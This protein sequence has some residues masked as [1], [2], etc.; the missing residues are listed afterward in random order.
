V[1]TA[2]EIKYL[3]E[4]YGWTV[5]PLTH[6][7][8]LRMTSDQCQFHEL[9]NKAEYERALNEPQEKAA[10]KK[11]AE[12]QDRVKAENQKISEL[13]AGKKFWTTQATPE[14]I[15]SAK[16]ALEACEKRYPQLVGSSVKSESIR[17]WLLTNNLPVTVAN[18]SRAFEALAREGRLVL[19]PAACGIIRIQMGDGQVL[20]IL[21][22]EL[23]AYQRKNPPTIE[24]RGVWRKTVQ[25]PIKILPA[26]ESVTGSELASHPLLKTL[27]QSFD[28]ADEAKRRQDAMSA[29]E[30]RNAH[31]EAWRDP[32]VYADAAK[33]IEQEINSFVSFHPEY[34]LTDENRKHMRAYLD[35][36]NLSYTL[37]NLETAYGE[38]VKEGYVQTNPEAVVS[39]GATKLVDLGAQ[40]PTPR[41]GYRPWDRMNSREFEAWVRIPANKQLVEDSYATA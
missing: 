11:A 25:K 39:S 35:K 31:P 34:V 33:Q 10:A 14:E 30:Y 38:L 13:W 17:E 1:K 27:L 4:K 2:N 7:G 20:D 36:R 29:D 21:A 16:T 41:G 12:E 40:T 15:Q 23:P 18:L 26:V 32:R 24:G 5:G 8:I 3:A 9:F 19:N 28:P 37:N 6:A 22:E